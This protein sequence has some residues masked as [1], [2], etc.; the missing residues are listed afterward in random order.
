MSIDYVPLT[1]LAKYKI[2]LKLKWN[3]WAKR[4]EYVQEGKRGEKAQT[5]T[6]TP[7]DSK[8]M[9]MFIEREKKVEN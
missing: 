9:I 6:H 3:L 8:S 1:S 5:H 2:H 4:A 7:N